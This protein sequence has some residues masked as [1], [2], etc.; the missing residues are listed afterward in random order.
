M[1]RT[2]RSAAATTA[3][4]VCLAA[5]TGADR[6]LVAPEEES[7]GQSVPESAGSSGPEPS[8]S[9]APP[10]GA[11]QVPPFVGALVLAHEDATQLTVTDFDSVRERLGVPGLTSEDLMTDRLEFWREL[12]ASTVLLTDGQLRE[13]NS[14]YDLA[15]GF[16][17]DDVSWEAHW[18][19]PDPGFVLQ[20]RADL[21]FGPVRTPSPPRSPAWRAPSRTPSTCRYVRA[22]R[23]SRPGPPTRRWPHWRT[24]TGSR[25]TCAVAVSRSTTPSAW[26]PRSRTRTRCSPRTT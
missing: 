4:L 3:A 15:Y 1:R 13:A 21:G 22:P 23:R 18:H 16:T 2:S 10:A 12:E 26:T 6:A 9:P 14:R 24:P 17:Q 19:G 8:Q 11:G 7:A 20:F 5:C 25:C